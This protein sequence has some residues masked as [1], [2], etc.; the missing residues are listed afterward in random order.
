MSSKS[1]RFTASGGGFTLP[2]LPY[3]YDALEPHIDAKT[4]QIHHSMHHATYVAG[5]NAATQ[6]SALGNDMRT[7]AGLQERAVSA[8][9]A[10]RNHGGG[11][12]N[13][14]LFWLILTSADKS[15]SVSNELK[16]SIN[17][18]F[19]GLQAFQ[20]QFAQAAA[21]RFGSGWAWLGVTPERR[22][23]I[24]STANQDNPLMDGLEYP[25]LKMTPILGLDVWEHA[26]YL[27][28]QN[29]RPEYITN[30][31]KVVNWDR[32]EENYNVA[33]AGDIVITE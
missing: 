4:M 19:G 10:V 2:N 6:G 32:V 16:A 5:L 14:S 18:D 23:A 22:L 9:V 26:Y 11:H 8:G 25:V 3:P 20:A 28:Y 7:L 12:Y 29:R 31:W 17:K 21:T 30:F 27:R 33:M 24:T 15:G 13:H 1:L